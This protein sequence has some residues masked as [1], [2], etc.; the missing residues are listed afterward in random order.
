[1][2][3]LTS[4]ISPMLGLA[5]GGGALSG[6]SGSS[7]PLG[8]QGLMKGSGQLIFLVVILVIFVLLAAA[9]AYILFKIVQYKLAKKVL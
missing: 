8:I 3:F 4:L 2:N 6:G 9:I 5:T 7:D 1:M